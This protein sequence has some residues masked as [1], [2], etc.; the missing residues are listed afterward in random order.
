M[1]N[2]TQGENDTTH[3]GETW[4]TNDSDEPTEGRKKRSS[5]VTSLDGTI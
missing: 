1:K 4:A 5:D 2:D 3:D